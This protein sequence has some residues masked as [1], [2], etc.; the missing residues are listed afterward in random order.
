MA[1]GESIATIPQRI[2]E[3]ISSLFV[4][5]TE[6]LNASIEDV[7]LKFQ[8]AFNISSLDI[9]GIF[10]DESRPSVKGHKVTV[11]N[12][13]T[14]NMPDIDF[15]FLDSALE[16]FRPIIRGFLVLL[17][18]FYNFNQYTKLIKAG[19]ITENSTPQSTNIKGGN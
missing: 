5:D 4:P 8:R 16:K 10:G 18:M 7:K 1:L 11:K 13:G 3:F 14:F 15:S 17:L 12:V 9:S 19:S 2:G 6:K